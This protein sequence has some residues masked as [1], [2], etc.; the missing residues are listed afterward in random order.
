MFISVDLPEPDVPMTAIISP[1]RRVRSTPR[2]ACT[3]FVA[4]RVDLLHALDLDDWRARMFVMPLARQNRP[5]AARRRAAAGTGCCVALRGAAAAVG[6]VAPMIT[7]MPSVMPGPVD[8]RLLS[9]GETGAHAHRLSLPLASTY[10]SWPTPRCRG[11][12]AARRAGAPPL[13]AAAAADAAAPRGRRA[14]RA[15]RAP[16]AFGR[17]RGAQS[18]RCRRPLHQL[19]RVGVKRSAAFGTVST[20]VAVP[21]RNCTVAVMPGSSL[22]LGSRRATTA[23]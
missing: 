19:A 3:S 21:V 17:R 23:V 12:R 13:T 2:S 9:V 8:L 6:R 7:C 11:A 22:P 15:A 18:R 20:F 5:P 14:C 1:A 10:Q 4:H 16:P